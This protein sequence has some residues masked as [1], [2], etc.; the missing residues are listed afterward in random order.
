MA[1]YVV[2]VSV[3]E[4]RLEAEVLFWYPKS[5]NSDARVWRYIRLDSSLEGDR[6][7]TDTLCE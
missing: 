5:S 2:P 4:V 1:I 7:N 3:T 6:M